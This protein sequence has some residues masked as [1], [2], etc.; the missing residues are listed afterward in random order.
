MVLFGCKRPGRMG[1]APPRSGSSSV[2]P[3]RSRR[4]E[5]RLEPCHRFCIVAPGDLVLPRRGTLDLAGDSR[6]DL[7]A[8]VGRYAVS[9]LVQVGG[10][11]APKPDMPQRNSVA[12]MLVVAAEAG[13]V[14]LPWLAV[15]ADVLSQDG[16]PAN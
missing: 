14:L 12:I 5:W 1:K 4:P 8:I 15:D 10:G 3:G 13:D 9:E 11:A 2:G 6:L 7:L 16:L